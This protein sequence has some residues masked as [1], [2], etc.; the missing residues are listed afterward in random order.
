MVLTVPAMEK[1]RYFVFQMMDLYTF[2]FDYVGSRTTGNDGGD[3]LIAGP[4]WKGGAQR[5]QEGHPLRDPTRQRGRP[6]AIVQSG[7]SRQRQENPGRLQIATV[8]RISR[9]AGAAGRARN[10]L[11]QADGAGR[12]E[13]VARVLQS[14]R[15]PAAVHLDQ[16]R[17]SPLRNASRASA[18]FRASRSTQRRCPMP[19]RRRC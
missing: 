9:Q 2:N 19:E 11:D 5:H 7:R 17:R 14:A 16:S 3:F 4:N 13:Q 18:S 15:V 10:Q 1:H 8:L 6:H 12:T